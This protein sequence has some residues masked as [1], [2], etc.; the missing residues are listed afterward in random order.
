MIVQGRWKWD[1]LRVDETVR[2][3]HPRVEGMEGNHSP[4][5]EC[6]HNPEHPIHK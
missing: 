3:K 6:D 4:A 2:P 5:L 1:I